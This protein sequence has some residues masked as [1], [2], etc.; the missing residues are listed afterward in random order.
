[1]SWRGAH[2]LR[3]KLNLLFFLVLSNPEED[4]ESHSGNGD[5]EEGTQEV[6]SGGGIVGTNFPHRYCDCVILFVGQDVWIVEAVP[7]IFCR[8]DQN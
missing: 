6:G 3:F 8:D 2:V 5:D 7:L 1:M 4:E